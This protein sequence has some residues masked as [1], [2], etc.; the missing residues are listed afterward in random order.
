M[1][2]A[3]SW[4]SNRKWSG[5]MNWMTMFLAYVRHKLTAY[6]LPFL[7]VEWMNFHSVMWIYDKESNLEWIV[8]ASFNMK[9][10]Q[11]SNIEIKKKNIMRITQSSLP[12]HL[13]WKWN[14]RHGKH[15][16]LSLNCRWTDAKSIKWKIHFETITQRTKW[17]KGI[18][19][20]WIM[21]LSWAKAVHISH[22]VYHAM[23]QPG[24]RVKM[25]FRTL[26]FATIINHWKYGLRK[27]L[28]IHDLFFL[29]LHC[30]SYLH[31]S[32]ILFYLAFHKV[33]HLHI[34]THDI[35]R[36]PEIVFFPKEWW[37]RWKCAEFDLTLSSSDACL[38]K[39]KTFETFALE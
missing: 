23:M 15:R 3:E 28:H 2:R 35:R 16:A 12:H 33:H 10:V 30:P 19:S 36:R 22:G 21:Y 11:I 14:R 7:S 25:L 24:Y 6:C 17:I 9:H 37:I 20:F 5:C 31:L 32:H 13:V 34:L 18:T 29:S 27:E 26:Q 38:L 8:A 4:E 1:S 39:P